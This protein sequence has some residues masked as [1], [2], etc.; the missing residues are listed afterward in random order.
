MEFDT[1]YPE[2]LHKRMLK[3]GFNIDSE[4]DL[5]HRKYKNPNKILD[6]LLFKKLITFF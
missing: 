3:V 4:I 5:L 2:Q 1:V 6:K